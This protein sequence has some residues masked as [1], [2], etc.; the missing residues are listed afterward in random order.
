MPVNYNQLSEHVATNFESGRYDEGSKSMLRTRKTTNRLVDEQSKQYLEKKRRKRQQKS[1][2]KQQKTKRKQQNSGRKKSRNESGSE[3]E[4]FIQ[5]NKQRKVSSNKYLFPDSDEDNESDI[6][7][8]RRRTIMKNRHN[9]MKTAQM[10]DND[11]CQQ[12]YDTE[13]DTI[14][15]Y[16]SIED[17]GIDFHLKSELKQQEKKD[18]DEPGVIQ[19]RE[20]LNEQYEHN[21]KSREKE[22]SLAL[23]ADHQNTMREQL[24]DA[25]LS[26]DDDKESTKTKKK[27]PIEIGNIRV[28]GNNN[29]I[30]INICPNPAQ[31]SS[32]TAPMMM[33][34]EMGQNFS[35]YDSSYWGQQQRGIPRFLTNGQH[36]HQPS[37]HYSH[38]QQQNHWQKPNESSIERMIRQRTSPIYHLLSRSDK[39][40]LGR[41][42]FVVKSAQS[43]TLLLTERDWV[44]NQRR[45]VRGTWKEDFINMVSF[46]CNA[47][48]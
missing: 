26:E 37:Y 39:E 24:F 12:H 14:E 21:K 20:E 40:W 38:H 32:Y 19:I 30:A 22:V 35:S 46:H 1:K 41:L 10:I 18:E 28:S 31:L 34:H 27:N 29:S 17:G 11:L 25:E 2:K 47:N 48:L 33:Q 13:K 15:E 45:E 36:Q 16:T 5:P 7:K 43:R 44:Y 9:N 23:A 8:E 3:E 6:D 42:I 4:E